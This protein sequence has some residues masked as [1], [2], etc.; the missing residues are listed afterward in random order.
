MSLVRPVFY[1][2]TNVYRHLVEPANGDPCE[3]IKRKRSRMRLVADTVLELIEDLYTCS[4]EPTFQ[5]RKKAAEL[6]RLIGGK[7][8]L[9][10]DGRFLVKKLF[11]PKLQ[12]RAESGKQAKKWLDVVVRYRSRS[13][14][15]QPV[16]YTVGRVVLDVQDIARRLQKMRSAYV[17]MLDSYKAEILRKAGLTSGAVRETDVSGPYA[18]AV[19]EYF[20]TD[21]WKLTYVRILARA[22]GATV[23]SDADALQFSQRLCVAC[24]FSGTTLRQSLCEGYKYERKANDALD[25]AHLRYLCDDSLVFVT[26]D[27]KLRGKIPRTSKGRVINLKEL[28]ARLK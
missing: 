24:E 8:V 25:E 22:V 6:A 11:D 17:R 5:A 4:S 28:V 14:V 21:E 3:I 15:G 10:A 7:T 1:L 26:D 12:E 18:S 9:P 27:N 23:G 20:R 2:D 19:N 13:D 16:R